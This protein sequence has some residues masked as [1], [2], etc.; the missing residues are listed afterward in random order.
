MLAA[1]LSSREGAFLIHFGVVCSTW[2]AISQGSCR[3]SFWAPLGD[4]ELPTVVNA[5]EM[6]GKM[7]CLLLVIQACGGTFTV[8]QPRSS[9]LYRHPAFQAVCERMRM[10]RCLG[11]LVAYIYLSIIWHGVMSK[12]S[13]ATIILLMHAS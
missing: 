6:V 12:A 1:I 13:M 2:V 8:E 9:L 7:C 3:R 5:N 11:A 10:W 4:T